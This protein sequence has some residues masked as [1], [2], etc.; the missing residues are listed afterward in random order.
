MTTLM[1]RGTVKRGDDYIL[2]MKGGM[3]DEGRQHNPGV[4]LG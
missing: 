1:V 3:K 4:G 2:H